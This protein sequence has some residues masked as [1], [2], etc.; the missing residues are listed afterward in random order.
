[1]DAGAGN[2]L[3]ESCT[4]ALK[5]K[6]KEAYG[7]EDELCFPLLV[8]RAGKKITINAVQLFYMRWAFLLSHNAVIFYTGV[9]VCVSVSHFEEV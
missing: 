4:A 6:Q 5:C 2:N 7:W 8:I 1:M 9:C 3:E